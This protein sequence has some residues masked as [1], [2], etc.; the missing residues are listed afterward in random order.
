MSELRK[1]A[2]FTMHHQSIYLETW[3]KQGFVVEPTPQ[4]P[5]VYK[6]LTEIQVCEMVRKK[7]DTLVHFDGVL[8]GGLTNLMCYAWYACST[9]N[10]PTYIIK[11]PRASAELIKMAS[12]D[13]TRHRG[14][15][16]EN[17]P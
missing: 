17:N 16:A 12:I 10:L 15:M 1:L 4:A 7:I 3:R 9:L 2:N 13:D 5:R 6:G 8:L 14:S 11:S